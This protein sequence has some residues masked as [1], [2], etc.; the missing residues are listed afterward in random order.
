MDHGLTLYIL[1]HYAQFMTPAEHLADRHLA[2]TFMACDGRTDREAQDQ[3]R[4]EGGVGAHWLSDDP[5]ILRLTADGLEAFRAQV[6][7]R[8]LS[9]HR[10]EIF[11]N[12]CP[13][14]GGLT[15]TPKA[16]L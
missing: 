3:L 5:A 16:R 12:Y 4:R 8:I 6:A 15:R 1:S 11:L 9:A 7:A 2:A 14:C 10:A 13:R